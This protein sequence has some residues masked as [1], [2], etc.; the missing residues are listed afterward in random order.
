MYHVYNVYNKLYKLITWEQDIAPRNVA[1][2]KTDSAAGCRHHRSSWNTVVAPSFAHVYRRRIRRARGA[3]GS[4]FPMTTA[5][6]RHSRTEQ[7]SPL[8]TTTALTTL[9]RHSIDSSYLRTQI[10]TNYLLLSYGIKSQCTAVM[11]LVCSHQVPQTSTI[12]NTRSTRT[13][14]VE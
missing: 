14:I 1:E 6:P 8:P 4:E 13:Y 10:H 9:A 7:R 12:Y 5:A 11:M 3:T 2:H